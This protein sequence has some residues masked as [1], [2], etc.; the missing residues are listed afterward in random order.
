MELNIYSY[1]FLPTF[2][3]IDPVI[4]FC[5]V[6]EMVRTMLHAYM[7]AICIN[8]TFACFVVILKERRKKTNVFDSHKTS[9][10][11]VPWAI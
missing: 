3:L 2:F 8:H 6:N 11:K 10:V 4:M 7:C 9:L 5:V 1:F